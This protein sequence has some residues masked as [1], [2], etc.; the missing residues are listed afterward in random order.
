VLSFLASNSFLISTFEGAVIVKSHL[1]E[2]FESLSGSLKEVLL[3]LKKEEEG[4]KLKETLHS[5]KVRFY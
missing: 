4:K 1:R 2:Y 5:L 3:L